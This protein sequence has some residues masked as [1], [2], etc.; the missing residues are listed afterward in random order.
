MQEEYDQGI[1]QARLWHYIYLS[2]SVI[3]LI[4]IVAIL[5]HHRHQQRI[6]K[7]KRAVSES[8]ALVNAHLYRIEELEKQGADGSKEAKQLRKE[9]ETIRQ[10]QGEM[11]AN[12]KER[13][14]E[15]VRGGTTIKWHKKDFTDFAEYYQILNASFI[16]SLRY[17]HPK[18]SPRSFFFLILLKKRYEKEDIKH[19]MGM[20]DNAYRTMK[21]R[22]GEEDAS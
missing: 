1:A 19:I 10:R 22:V 2:V 4:V 9:I 6:E 8:Q 3:L 14:E 5:L 13:Y 16:L 20:S 18:L 17:A 11:I 15:I 21:S 7:M 12:G